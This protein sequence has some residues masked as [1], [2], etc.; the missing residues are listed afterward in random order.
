MSNKLFKTV[1]L[2]I[3]VAIPTHG[4][5]SESYQINYKT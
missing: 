5:L 3:Y 1:M 2:V 4:M